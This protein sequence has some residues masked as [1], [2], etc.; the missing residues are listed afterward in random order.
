MPAGWYCE[1]PAD[2]SPAAVAIVGELFIELKG[3]EV[4]LNQ[5]PSVMSIDDGYVWRGPVNRAPCPIASGGVRAPSTGRSCSA[6]RW[7]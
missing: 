5:L 2:L 7:R 6:R 4:D 1:A 3:L